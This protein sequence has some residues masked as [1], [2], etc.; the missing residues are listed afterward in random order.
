MRARGIV[1]GQNV[2]L[3]RLADQAL[4]VR[5]GQRAAEMVNLVFIA[6]RGSE[7][8]ELRRRFPSSRDYLEPQAVRQRDDG[9]HDR[10]ILGT[11]HDLVDEHTVD[12]ELIDRKATQIAH[13][14]IAVSKI[15]DRDEHSHG[16]QMLE[17]RNR[18]LGIA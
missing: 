6:T 12:L 16:A 18:F 14:R 2:L 1:L 13:T 7:K 17:Y 8:I 11:T 5:G 15:I 9:A 4:E 3:L 10:R